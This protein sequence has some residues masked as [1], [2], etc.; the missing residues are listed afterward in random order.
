MRT[1]ISCLA[2]CFLACG[3]S[4][5]DRS[6][7]HAEALWKAV[8]RKQQVKL[9]HVATES[10]CAIGSV[11]GK[12]LESVAKAAERAVIFAKKSV[13]YDKKPEMRENQ[14]MSE[15]PYQ[16]EEKLILIVCK[17]R[18]EFVDFFTRLKTGKP[19]GGE[20]SA[21]AHD[22]GMTYVLLGPS[23][24]TSRRVAW[25]VEGVKL[26]GEATLTRRHAP[27]PHWFVQGY[28]RMLA[29]RYDP[30]AFAAERKK[31]MTWG[32]NRHVQDILTDENANVPSEAL[33][34]LQT[35]LV[36]CLTQ[37]PAF[38]DKWYALLDESAYREN[39][40]AALAEQK[41]TLERLQLEWKSWIS[42]Y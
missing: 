39:V 14:Q 25:E 27:L 20:I 8:V 15:R 30:K 41:I 35:S 13:G 4:A 16:W 22:K 18:N 32:Q 3:I 40:M 11:E 42:K 37:S 5:E 29:Y 12:S 24:A 33:L 10:V 21:Y 2:L 26:A 9:N 23:G 6:K 28:G 31:I 17:E 1:L 7:D 36:E 19:D 38:Q 34:P